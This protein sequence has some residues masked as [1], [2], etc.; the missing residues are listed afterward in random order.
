MEEPKIAKELMSIAMQNPE[1][2]S[3]AK[4]MIELVQVV[5]ERPEVMQKLKELRDEGITAHHE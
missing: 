5:R 2:L 3:Q 1:I 4:E